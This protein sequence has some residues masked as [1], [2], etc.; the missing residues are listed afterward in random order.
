MYLKNAVY[1]VTV[2]GK[3]SSLLMRHFLRVQTD[4]SL[5]NALE[6]KVEKIQEAM[7]S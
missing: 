2:A 6:K 7:A 4:T 5:R 1:V 3:S